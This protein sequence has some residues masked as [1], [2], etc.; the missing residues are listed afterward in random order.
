MKLDMSL[1]ELL[2]EADAIARDVQS[3]FGN[4]TADQM[5]V[6]DERRHFAQ[7]EHVMAMNGFPK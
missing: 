7:A 5:I 6:V 2:N 4:L 3:T 1:P